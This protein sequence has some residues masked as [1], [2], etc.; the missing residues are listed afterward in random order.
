MSHI[1]EYKHSNP[2]ITTKSSKLQPHM[3]MINKIYKEVCSHV[4]VPP[5]VQVID[6]S[7]TIRPNMQISNKNVYINW[8]YTDDTLEKKQYDYLIEH[9]NNDNYEKISGKNIKKLYLHKDHVSIQMNHQDSDI[10]CI[11]AQM[12]PQKLCYNFIIMRYKLDIIQP[13]DVVDFR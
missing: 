4:R 10:L 7:L 13:F 3:F 8:S 6:D 11:E 2:I 1:I 12:W 5:I 9:I